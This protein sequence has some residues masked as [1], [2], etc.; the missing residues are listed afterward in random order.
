MNKILSTLLFTTPIL[1]TAC[2][3]TTN[4]VKPKAVESDIQFVQEATVGV[5]TP[6]TKATSSS[7]TYANDKKDIKDRGMLHIKGFMGTLQPTLMGMMKSD[8][9]HKTAL[10][11]CSTLGQSMA[12]DYNRVSNVKIRRTAL[13]YRNPKNRP[14]A[15]DTT[16]MERFLATKEFNE[17]LVVDMG[18][19]YRVYKALEVKQPCLACH[20]ENIS[21]DLQKMLI[22]KYPTDMATNFKLGDFRGAVVAEIKK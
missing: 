18:D 22:R 3:S 15:T 13:R 10:G 21:Q 4:E 2:N 17:P 20:G 9:T 16:V 14:D 12:D 7:V 8:P 1:F 11:A 5:S 19:S 6:S